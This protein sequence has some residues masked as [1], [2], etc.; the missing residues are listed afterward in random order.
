MEFTELQRVTNYVKWKYSLY[1]SILAHYLLLN[2]D[3]TNLF[4]F[5]FIFRFM[6]DFWI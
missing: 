5:F 2:D 1:T 4:I 6:L 3:I